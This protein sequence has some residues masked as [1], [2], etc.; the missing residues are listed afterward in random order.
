MIA[1]EIHNESLKGHIPLAKNFLGDA[2]VNVSY[3]RVPAFDDA[4]GTWRENGWTRAKV[5]AD[6]AM[7]AIEKGMSF[8]EAM[9]TFGRFKPGDT[10]GGRL[11]AKSFNELRQK[12]GESEYLDFVNG[13]S[14]AQMLLNETKEGQVIGPVRAND[15]YII[16]K[17]ITRVPPGGSVTVE[18]EKTREL[19]K[20]DYISTRF[21]KWAGEVAARMKLE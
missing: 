17:L 18:D 2:R 21:L 7:D 9:K 14:I 3:I 1:K 8:D 16:A 10:E 5:E 13:Y 11:G 12:L 6:G 15:G 4:T 20:Q 19:I